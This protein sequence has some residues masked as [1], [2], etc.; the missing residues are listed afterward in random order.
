MTDLSP[1]TTG[2]S[3]NIYSAML[4][5]ESLAPCRL[6]PDSGYQAYGLLLSLL[7]ERWPETSR[8]LHQDETAKPF[9]LSPLMAPG[10]RDRWKARLEQGTVASIRVT[11]LAQGLFER[12]VDSVI[13]LP[14][15][16][17]VTLGPAAFHV[18]ALVT[19]HNARPGARM[20]SFKEL[21]ENAGLEDRFTLRFASPTTFRSGGKRNVVFPAPRLVFGSLLNRWNAR[22]AVVGAL[23]ARRPRRPGHACRMQ[24]IDPKGGLRFVS[25]A[26]SRRRVQLPGLRGSRRRRQVDPVSAGGFRVLRGSRREDDDGHGP[27]LA[28]RRRRAEAAT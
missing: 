28:S 13:S 25:G 26:G 14:V 20:T 15:P 21:V 17:T 1:P 10:G 24:A 9:T 23:A 19:R 5:L 18:R 4:E 11:C 7:R 27:V 8:R 12:L 6:S 22:A 16:A 3:G 2:N